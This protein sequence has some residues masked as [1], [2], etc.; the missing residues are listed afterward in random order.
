MILCNNRNL[1]YFKK[2]NTHVHKL[3][4][5]NPYRTWIWMPPRTPECHIPYIILIIGTNTYQFT[6]AL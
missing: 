3:N 5:M 1:I 2:G 4:E 6:S